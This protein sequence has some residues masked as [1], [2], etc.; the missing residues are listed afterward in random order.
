MF[1]TTKAFRIGRIKLAASQISTVDYYDG[2]A[3]S[4]AMNAID[5]ARRDIAVKA[6]TGFP[7]SD[8][9]ARDWIAANGNIAAHTQKSVVTIAK[10]GELNVSR[11]MVAANLLSDLAK[12]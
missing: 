4:H 6:L 9:P 12:A 2:L 1:R 10:S 5:T 11:L 3:L 7:K 8:N